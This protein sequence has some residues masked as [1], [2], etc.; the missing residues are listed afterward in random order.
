MP[1]LSDKSNLRYPAWQDVYE[2]TLRESSVGKLFKLVEIA[3]AAMLT[4]R[5]LLDRS[6]SGRTERRAI[7]E[8]L[9][10]LLVIKQGQLQFSSGTGKQRVRNGGSSVVA[11]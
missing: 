2:A 8:A 10:V 7:E 1:S 6:C 11:Q 4:R 5:D 9:R 3:E